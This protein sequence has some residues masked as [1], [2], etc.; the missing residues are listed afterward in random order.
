[1]DPLLKLLAA[2]VVGC[3]GIVLANLWVNK[4]VAPFNRWIYRRGMEPEEYDRLLS[5]RVEFTLDLGRA[6]C[7]LA[8]IAL[9][10]III[11]S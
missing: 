3:G 1:M 2:I 6:G 9:V 8:V 11:T 10:L 5:R 7:Y 4:V